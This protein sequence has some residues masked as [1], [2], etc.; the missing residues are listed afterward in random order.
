MERELRTLNRAVLRA[1]G[2]GAALALCGAALAQQAQKVEK[3]EVT[4]SNIKRIEGET[5]LPVTVITREQ[6]EQQGITTAMEAVERLS[7]NSSVGGINLSGSI[8]GTSVGFAAA[9]LRGLGS[10]RTLVL[11][12]GRRLANTAFDGASVDINAIPLSAV[13]RV[14]ILSDGA[15]AIYGTDAVAGVINFILRKDFTGVEASAYY[16][17]SQHGGGTV[18]RYT[19]TL[20]WGD[21]ATRRFNAF[22]S[23][24]YNKVEAIAAS[25]RHFSA[26]AYL[27]GAPD[28][29]YDRTSGNSFPGN[30]FLPAVA[31]R[32]GTTQNPTYPTCARPFSFQTQNPATAGQC[33]FD[34]ASVIDILP[35]SESYNAFGSARFQ[36]APGHQLFVEGTWQRT[37]SIARASPSPIS[38]ATILS[39]EPV[40]TSPG[41]PFY[42]RDLAARFGVNGQTLEVFWRGL[43]L[44]PRTDENEVEQSRWVAGLEGNLGAWDYSAA[45]NGSQSKATDTWTA[46]W[47]R[48]SVLLPI[49]NSGRVNLFGFNTPEVLAEMQAA[50]VR[51][52]VI[53]A[54]GES[55]ELDFRAS[56][57]LM[58]LRSGALAVALGGNYRQEKYEYITSQTVRDADVPGLGGSIATVPSISRNVYAVFGEVNV[59]ILRNLE[60]NAALRFDD[61]EDVG[62]TTNPKVSLRYTPGKEALFRVAYG[63]GFRAPS[64]PELNRP[65]YYG[66][67]GGNYDDPIRCPSTGSPRDCNTQ[68]TTRL[69]GNV[70]LKP[71]KSRNFTAGFVLEPA[72]GLSFGADYF[73]IRI[74]DV[75][76]IPAET[77][78]FENI[79]ASEAAGLLVRYA[80]GSAGCPT[81]TP[82][83][84][85]PVN[86]GIQTLV[87]LT[88]LRTEGIDVNASYRFPR[89]GWGRLSIAFNGTY[90]MKWDQKSVGQDTQR[91]AGQFGGGVAATVIGSGS[92]GGFPH[93]KHVATVA[94]DMGALQLT[95]HQLFVGHYTD[96]EAGR[97]V[98]TYSTIGLNAAYT[99]WRNLTL[100]LGVKNVFDTDPPYTRQNQSFQVGYDPALADP[101]GR[102]WYAGLRYRFR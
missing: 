67:T 82:G 8:G 88:E 76:G 72:A 28:G 91:L 71:E 101:T 32:A 87:N 49:L 33:R 97:T 99:A 24:D 31:G 34:F 25:Q 3:I 95:A 90:L 45:Y 44:G 94:A 27:P 10:N 39:G 42:P 92:T 73:N 74:D 1:L 56:R 46:G 57:D 52:P 16:G 79:A 84:P 69:G 48:G 4:G 63:T 66:A 9:S 30:V 68:F 78:I 36:V 54:K 18:K 100:T 29:V 21:L 77:P 41:S 83:L 60:A 50:L 62:S 20:G 80:P 59:P 96:A 81:P 40:T 13:E 58:Q 11:L 65:N 15:S 61:Y 37:T 86:Y 14:E 35:P 17:D 12:N 64:L 53:K 98:G 75:I 7:S 2:A 102:F 22:A 93:W 85:C 51:E 89:M 47:V 19:A 38:S 55:S 23:F 5:A 70:A 26:S 6:L 43:E